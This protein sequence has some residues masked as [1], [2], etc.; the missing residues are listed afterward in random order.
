MHLGSIFLFGGLFF[1]TFYMCM[2]TTATTNANI[3]DGK[4]G[5]NSIFSHTDVSCSVI[6]K[7][8]LM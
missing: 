1:F 5:T 3:P 4:N 6:S 8:D 2:T 7:F